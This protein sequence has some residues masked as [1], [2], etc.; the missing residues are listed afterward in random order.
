MSQYR[1][2]H[3]VI[4]FKDH[5][6]IKT[7]SYNNE[8]KVIAVFRLTATASITI[9]IH[10]HNNKSPETIATRNIYLLKILIS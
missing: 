3:P 6:V 5:R 7:C 8:I 10:K 4:S 2:K 1:K 9:I